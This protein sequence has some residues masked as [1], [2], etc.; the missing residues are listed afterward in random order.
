ML[1]VARNVLRSVEFQ[2]S[3][4]NYLLL[5]IYS[6]Y[7]PNKTV[8]C[9]DKDPT[10]MTNGIRTVIEMKNNAYKEYIRSSMR[11]NYYVRLENITTELSNLIHDT[12]TEYHSKL[13][14]KLFNPSTSAKI[15]WSILTTIAKGRKV[16]VIHPLKINNEFLIYD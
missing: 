3:E 9:D 13:A 4:L 15:Y 8:L 6:N 2:V 11:H 10:W 1:W 14:A 16:P 7:V 5:N 12:K